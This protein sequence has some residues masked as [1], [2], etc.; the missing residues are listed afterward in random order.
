MQVPK[1]IVINFSIREFNKWLKPTLLCTSL[2]AYFS[3]REFNK[4]LKP[5][6]DFMRFGQNFSIREFNK[7]LKRKDT[8][9]NGNSEF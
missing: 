1:E 9:A 4:W 2:W 5:L 7:W 3:I 8:L 6:K